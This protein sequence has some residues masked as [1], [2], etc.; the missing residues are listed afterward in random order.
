MP[1][2]P[3]IDQPSLRDKE[4]RGEKRHD[5][6]DEYG[7]KLL[8]QISRRSDGRCSDLAHKLAD[9]TADLHR[10]VIDLQLCFSRKL[11]QQ[12][13]QGLSDLR[14]IRLHALPHSGK[15]TDQSDNLLHQLRYDKISQQDDQCNN[16]HDD[17]SAADLTLD[18]YL[19]L[20][21]THQR[22]GNQCNDPACHERRKENNHL[23]QKDDCRQKQR[24]CNRNID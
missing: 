11:C 17:K 23:R 10:K 18:L 6:T 5:D 21:E 3:F 19:L 8:C 13:I 12:Y 4:I 22:A 1:A 15:G 14:K 16:H 7:R 20:K 9:V 24:D 2:E